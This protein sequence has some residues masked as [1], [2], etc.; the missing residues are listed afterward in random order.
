MSFKDRSQARTSALAQA[1]ETYH[2]QATAERLFKLNDVTTLPAQTRLRNDEQVT[3]DLAQLDLEIKQLQAS[4]QVLATAEANLGVWRARSRNL[5]SPISMLPNEILGQIFVCSLPRGRE[6]VEF[7]T[8]VSTVCRLWRE[9]ALRFRALWSVFNLRWHSAREKA[10]LERSS[11]H[12]LSIYVDFPGP[13]GEDHL[14]SAVDFRGLFRQDGVFCMAENW[15]SAEFHIGTSY[16]HLNPIMGYLP[17]H[18]TGLRSLTIA[19]CGF[20]DSYEDA[21]M[22]DVDMWPFVHDM[23]NLTE[24]VIRSVYAI[25]LHDLVPR[26]RVLKTNTVG[27]QSGASG[28]VRR[29]MDLFRQAAA[30]EDLEADWNRL[31]SRKH[32]APPPWRELPPLDMG[33]PYWGTLAVSSLRRLK[34][35]CIDWRVC[36]HLFECIQLPEL[37]SISIEFDK[38]TFTSRSVFEYDLE[39]ALFKF[40]SF[41]WSYVYSS[42]IKLLNLVLID[43]LHQRCRLQS[44]SRDA[45]YSSQLFDKGSLQLF[46]FSARPRSF[47]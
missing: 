43:V 44:P 40:V 26:L 8:A 38:V 46:D 1:I 9:I 7:T 14:L 17:K 27:A 21:Q 34:L 15:I 13:L 47:G 36:K 12:P 4:R 28:S 32:R 16:T 33:D 20:S 24:I 19:D 23:P 29:W 42:Q 18:C 11:G 2:Q 6:L 30:L 41:P 45:L 35:H 3:Q 39:D 31:G 10:W 22:L 37:E 5:L 25:N